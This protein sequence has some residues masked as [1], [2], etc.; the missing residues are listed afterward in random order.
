MPRIIKAR[1]DAVY[2]VLRKKRYVE[3]VGRILGISRQTA[4]RYI[5]YWYNKGK[6][7]KERG[8]KLRNRMYYWR[9]SRW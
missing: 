7:H 9:K 4:K 6:L 8:G 1:S 2:R 3:E 5:D